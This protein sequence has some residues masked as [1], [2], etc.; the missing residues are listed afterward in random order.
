MKIVKG[1]F[2]RL[3]LITET[4]QEGKKLAQKVHEPGKSSN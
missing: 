3:L 1:N 4:G 2:M